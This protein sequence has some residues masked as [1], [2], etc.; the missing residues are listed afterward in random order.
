MKSLLPLGLSA[1]FVLLTA[2][3]PEPGSA[4]W[5]EA[6]KEQPKSQWT[7]DDAAT[8]AS[9]CL[10]DDLTI[11]SEAWCERLR[12][13]PKGEWTADEASSYARHCVM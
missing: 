5:C 8:F 4:S 3:A 10:I 11:G 1:C 2:C 6:K 7:M 13:R 12:D 9:H